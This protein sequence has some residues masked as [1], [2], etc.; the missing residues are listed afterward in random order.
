[1]PTT[2][3]PPDD[4]YPRLLWSRLNV[5]DQPRV[6]PDTSTF[7]WLNFLILEFFPDGVL[8]GDVAIVLDELCTFSESTLVFNLLVH[9]HD[10]VRLFL[11]HWYARFVGGCNYVLAASDARGRERHNRAGGSAC[12]RR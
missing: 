10:P 6:P 4:T 2:L 12:G 3:W 5:D 11:W 8:H 1:M 9:Q 7:V